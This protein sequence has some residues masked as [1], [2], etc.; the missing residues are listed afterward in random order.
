M[1]HNIETSGFSGLLRFKDSI[2]V[3]LIIQTEISKSLV[4]A[5]I[6]N[7]LILF[8]VIFEDSQREIGN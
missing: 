2:I 4:Y 3:H 1:I 8:S 5:N 7:S 6:F